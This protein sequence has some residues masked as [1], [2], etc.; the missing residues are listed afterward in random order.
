MTFEEFFRKATDWQEHGCSG[1]FLKA[2][3]SLASASR[4]SDTLLPRRPLTRHPVHHVRVNA[5]RDH[6]TVAKSAGGGTPTDTSGSD[7]KPR[8]QFNGDGRGASRRRMDSSTTR[9]PY[10][11][12][13]HIQARIGV[14]DR[15][16]AGSRK[17]HLQSKARTRLN[18]SARIPASVVLIR[19]CKA[20]RK[21]NFGSLASRWALARRPQTPCTRSH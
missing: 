14:L 9:N 21:L 4:G 10:A 7:S 8:G 12:A 19:G 11:S 16:S 13:R 6:Q 2:V 5:E 3:E 17:R 15:P 1:F 18:K 20:L